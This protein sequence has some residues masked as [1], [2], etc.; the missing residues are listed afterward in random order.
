MYASFNFN[1]CCGYVSG[2]GSGLD[3]DSMGSLDPDP[4]EQKWPSKKEKSYFI[5]WIAGCSLLRT[6]GFSCSL[7]VLYGGLEILIKKIFSCIFFNFR[8]SEPWIRNR[9]YSLEMLD[10]DTD[11]DSRNPDPQQ[12][13]HWLQPTALF[14]YLKQKKS[15]YFDCIWK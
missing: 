9:V 2:F 5:F 3:P 6:E 14:R 4:G 13:Q 1:Q 15:V 7:D 10:P 8:S 11:P 12:W